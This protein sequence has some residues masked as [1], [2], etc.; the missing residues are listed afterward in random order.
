MSLGCC[1]L[2]P[3]AELSGEC[4]RVLQPGVHTSAPLPL[5]TA[6][7]AVN[8]CLQTVAPGWRRGRQGSKRPLLWLL[9]LS[10][11]PTLILGSPL[12]PS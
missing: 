1:L 7:N 9:G 11:L 2:L 3:V 10:S 4:W 12:L 8:V 6:V 5:D